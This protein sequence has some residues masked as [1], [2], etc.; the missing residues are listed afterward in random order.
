[1]ERKWATEED[2][3]SLILERARAH[4]IVSLSPDTALFVAIKLATA[5]KK[6]TEREIIYALCERNCDKPCFAC[7]GKANA[8]TR[9]YGQRVGELGCG[10][11]DQ[12]ES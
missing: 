1:M 4:K 3:A 7:Y 12:Q 8:I 2:L 10:E 6:P 11:Q 9:L 5:S